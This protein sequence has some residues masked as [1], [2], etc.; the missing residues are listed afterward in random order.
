V[1]ALPEVATH[2]PASQAPELVLVPDTV[3][4]EPKRKPFLVSWY[5]EYARLCEE[6]GLSGRVSKP[7]DPAKCQRM[8]K[9]FDRLGEIIG[10]ATMGAFAD[11]MTAASIERD[12]NMLD[13][14]PLGAGL[15]ATIGTVALYKFLPGKK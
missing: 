12:G 13:K 11:I 2:E 6:D 1:A 3:V 14:I 5:E 10:P 9:L 15:G 7:V 8:D 4:E